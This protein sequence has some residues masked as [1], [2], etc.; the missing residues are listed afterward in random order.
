MNQEQ[1]DFAAKL[2]LIEQDARLVLEDLRSNAARARVEQLLTTAQL[3]RARLNVASSVILATQQPNEEQHD[4]AAKL[5]QISKEAQ[6]MLRE[7]PPGVVRDRLQHIATVG[8]LLLE[9][10]QKRAHGL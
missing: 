3:L 7:L 5:A 2:I 6:R 8:E 1:E 4:F 10:L 9:V